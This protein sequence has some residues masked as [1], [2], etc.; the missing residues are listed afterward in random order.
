MI[1]NIRLNT[2]ET[3][4]TQKK[5]FTVTLGFSLIMT[6]LT[7]LIGCVLIAFVTGV[8]V[9]RDAIKINDIQEERYAQ[10]E[11]NVKKEV[12]S[13]NDNAKQKIETSTKTNTSQSKEENTIMSPEDLK[14]AQDLR[15]KP[16]NSSQNV[17]LKNKTQSSKEEIVPKNSSKNKSI[18]AKNQQNVVQ[19]KV[20]NQNLLYD[21]IFQVASFKDEA[22]VDKLREKLEGK[23]LRTR[24]KKHGNYYQVLVLLRGNI[25]QANALQEQMIELKLGK[26]IQQQKKIVK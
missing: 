15:A 16:I 12:V 22:T 18:Q 6:S 26:P 23:G 24:M 17:A 8:I 25:N 11:E 3:N 10:Q 14:Y 4:P 5:K 7:V 2:Q 21:F 9:G 1:Q 19:K 20:I 13:Q